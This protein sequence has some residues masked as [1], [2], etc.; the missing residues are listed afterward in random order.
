LALPI[1]V[2]MGAHVGEPEFLAL[3]DA[4]GLL[5]MHWKVLRRAIEDGELRAYKLRSRVRIR[6][7]DLDQ[8]IESN[9]V[10]P[11]VHDI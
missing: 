9:R 1:Y 3:R 7:S 2:G 6:R 8:W 10:E 5:G 11:S 4:A